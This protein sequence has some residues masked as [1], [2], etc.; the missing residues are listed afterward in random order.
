MFTEFFQSGVVPGDQLI[1][2][3]NIYLIILSYMVA[4]FASFIALDL[5]GR[6][7][8][9]SNTKISRLSWLIG[10][11]I[12]MGS[13]IWSMHFIG[14]LSFSIPG[15]SLQYGLFWTFISLF[16]AILASGFALFL[17]QQSNFNII[18]LMAGGI[19]L[20]LA[21]ASMHYTGMEAMLISLNFRYLPSLFFISILIAIVASEAAIWL[22]LKSTKVMLT[23]RNQIKFISATIMGMAICG[24]HYTGMAASVFTPLCTP[25]SGGTHVAIDPVFLAISI[26]AVTFIIL[27][28]A[29]FASNYKE[30]LNQQEYEKARQLGM[31]EISTSVLHNVGNVLNSVNV[32]ASSIAEQMAMTKLSGLE[33]LSNLLN[34][35]KD[36]L[37]DFITKDP[38][39]GK[40]LEYLN[41]LVEYWKNEQV[42]LSNEVNDLLKNTLLIKNIISAQQGLS[43][44]MAVEHIIS[45]NQLVDECLLI[46]G[47]YLKHEIV[48][49]KKYEKISPIV[50][51]K[52]KLLQ[53]IVNILRNAKDALLASS[54]QN[55]LLIIKTGIENK[56]KV[57]IEITDNGIGVLAKNI[58]KIFHHGFTTKEVGH[59]FGLH[60]SYI[61]IRELGGDLHVKSAG[62]GKG[63][64]FI[65]EI[66]YKLP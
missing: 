56:N 34:S 35:H 30:A 7:R 45:I 10:G 49:E 27:G 17:L 22:A 20:G 48:V 66:P 28:I 51:D 26:A 25:F 39:G 47:L 53:I 8:D 40:V 61:S 18:H 55:K 16:V 38:R 15:L 13:G 2:T 24:M 3:Y 6:L 29:F 42:S 5:T 12:A 32:A 50:V 60:M 65:I 9:P 14:M 62:E 63:A 1:G 64:T 11:A 52:L 59:G 36:N 43:K 21:I 58:E 46:S 41:N 54:S 31:A 44:S 37:G 33:K 23:F 57:V 19:I 4:V